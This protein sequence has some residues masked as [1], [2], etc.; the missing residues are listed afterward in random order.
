MI[1]ELAIERWLSESLDA[2]TAK[3]LISNHIDEILQRKEPMS[4]WIDVSTQA[5]RILVEL[6][7]QLHTPVKPMLIIPLEDMSKTIVQAIPKN[8]EEAQAQLTIEPPSLYLID[9]ETAAKTEAVHE[10]FNAPLPFKLTENLPD[11][12]Y[13]Y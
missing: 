7:S 8:K 12:V 2:V 5:F 6:L 11:K 4:E 13:V 1:I 9:W 3:K 10:E